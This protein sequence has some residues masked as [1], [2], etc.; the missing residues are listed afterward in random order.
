[1]RQPVELR[2]EVAASTAEIMEALDHANRTAEN[3]M[4]RAARLRVVSRDKS[5]LCDMEAAAAML[6][7]A[8]RMRRCAE[9]MERQAKRLLELYS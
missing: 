2:E 5:G 3:A 4:R 1:M 8:E 9:Q 7:A 6:T